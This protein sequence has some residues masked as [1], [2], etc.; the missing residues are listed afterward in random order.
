MLQ[1]KFTTELSRFL[2]EEPDKIMLVNG[3]RQIGKS[4]L[5]RYV[6]QQQFAHYIFKLTCK[7]T[8]KA[9]VRSRQLH[10]YRDGKKILILAGKSTP[11]II[12]DDQLNQLL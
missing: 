8:K 6:S 2:Q 1:R 11:K 7:L 10:I 5:I 4:Y 12:R 9:H 3:A